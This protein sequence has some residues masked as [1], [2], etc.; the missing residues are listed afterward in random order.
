MI[1]FIKFH[2]F[3]VDVVNGLNAVIDHADFRRLADRRHL[4]QVINNGVELFETVAIHVHI[5]KQAFPC[6]EVLRS[7]VRF[8]SQGTD[9]RL[10]TVHVVKAPK[11]I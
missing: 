6:E 4:T 2:E 5:V 3:G 11:R 1:V 9:Q 7:L 10:Q 8:E